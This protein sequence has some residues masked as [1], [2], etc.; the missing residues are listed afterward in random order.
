VKGRVQGL[1]DELEVR[2]GHVHIPRQD[3]EYAVEVGLRMLV[4]RHLVIEKDGL[5]RPNPGETVLLRYY[6]NSIAHLVRPAVVE[7]AKV[8]GIDGGPS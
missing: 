8:P 5:Y 3:R 6:A 2:G 4:S 7:V 1:M